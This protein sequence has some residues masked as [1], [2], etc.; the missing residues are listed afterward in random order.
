MRGPGL[1]GTVSNGIAIARTTGTSDV[2]Y[3]GII[4]NDSFIA[5]AHLVKDGPQ[6]VQSLVSFKQAIII[7]LNL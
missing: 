6:E 3:T 1:E 5:S 2:Y 7:S 4:G